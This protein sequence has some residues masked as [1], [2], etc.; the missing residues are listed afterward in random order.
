MAFVETVA[1]NVNLIIHQLLASKATPYPALLPLFRKANGTMIV[2]VRSRNGEALKV[3][4]KLHGGGHANA[5][6][7]TLR[8]SIQSVSEANVY[9][10]KILKPA[11]PENISVNS[12][13]SAFDSVE[14]QSEGHK[15]AELHS[16]F[17]T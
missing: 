8:R 10:R 16:D 6:G 3:A 7:A 2:S 12:L 11:P 4:E 9:L 17:E 15:R 14:V 1:G 13:E 5:S